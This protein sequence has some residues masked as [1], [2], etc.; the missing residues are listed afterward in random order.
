MLNRRAGRFLVGLILTA[1]A[2]S[3]V[4]ASGI[5]AANEGD[6]VCRA[7]M[8]VT[9]GESCTYPGTSD[10]FRVGGEG[11]GR[12]LSFT[13]G[14]LLNARNVTVDGRTYNLAAHS[15]GD[16]G[17]TVLV[18]GDPAV[19]GPCANDIAVPD[20]HQ[21]QGLL[22]DCNALL[23]ARDALA[24]DAALD[25]SAD[26]PIAEW[27]GVTTGGSPA[28]VGQMVLGRR[29][30]TGIIPAQLG[31]LT[32]L[33]V[34][35]LHGNR[36]SG[37]IPPQLGSLTR[38]EV[39][40]LHSNRLSGPIPAQLGGLTRLEVLDLHDNWLSGPIP[41]ELGNLAALDLAAQDRLSYGNQLGGFI[42][43]EL[44][45]L[46]DLEGLLLNGNRLT[47]HI[48][49]W[50]GDLANLRWLLLHDN[51]LTGP[52]PPQMGSLVHLEGLYLGGNQ[53]SGPIPPEL[54]GLSNLV[55]LWLHLNRLSGPIPPELG[56]LTNLYW[57]LLYKNQLSGPI[58]PEL[59]NLRQ[60]GLLHL[61]GNRITG[62]ISHQLANRPALQI[63]HDGLPECKVTSPATPEDPTGLPQPDPSS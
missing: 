40:N 60:I 22:G 10:E 8:I 6:R 56:S 14:G 23:A 41:P 7:G 54:G 44:G 32:R 39:L 52:I 11:R 25:W 17:W 30:L 50:L 62:C 1:L 36:L 55:D 18:V 2:M 51:R 26:L 5:A 48:P 19:T 53:L 24:G 16:G 20:P 13:A 45:S 3:P 49:S 9:Q 21:N 59:G 57:L 29:G 42:P 27:E 12:F 15:Q 37:P 34:L 33:E 38:L 63:T 4:L 46:V 43:P 58:P 31:G 28:R 61:R 47:G 35:D